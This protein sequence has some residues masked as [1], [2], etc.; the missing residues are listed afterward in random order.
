[1]CFIL[2]ERRAALRGYNFIYDSVATSI[3][4]PLEPV[5]RTFQTACFRAVCWCLQDAACGGC[6]WFTS[7]IFPS[8]RRTVSGDGSST[9][10]GRDSLC[11]VAFAAVELIYC[12]FEIVL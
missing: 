6:Y 4:L 11:T 1:M 8:A 3:W 7:I 12:G 2:L 9:V 5:F 10:S